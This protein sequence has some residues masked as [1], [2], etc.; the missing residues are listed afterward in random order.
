MLVFFENQLLTLLYKA[1]FLQSQLSKTAARMVSMYEAGLNVE[2]QIAAEKREL[3]K[4][5]RQRQNV[6]ILETYAGIRNLLSY[7]KE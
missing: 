1:I 6:L 2:K 7:R 4:A 5:S 3:T